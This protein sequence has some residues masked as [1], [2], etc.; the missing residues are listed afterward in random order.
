MLVPTVHAH[1][2]RWAEQARSAQLG[3]DLKGADREYVARTAGNLLDLS[4]DIGRAIAWLRAEFP[5]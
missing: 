3:L 2:R 1:M 4:L 5:S